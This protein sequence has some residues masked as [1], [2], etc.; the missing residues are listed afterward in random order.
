MGRGSPLRVL[1]LGG[2]AEASALARLLAGEACFTPLLSL[3]GRTVSPV[4][5]PI[6]SRIG[7]FGGADGLAAFLRIEG[8]DLLIDAT[9]PFAHQISINAEQASAAA[10]VPRLVLR[11]PAW[12]PRQGDDWRAVPDMASAAI[13]L[14]EA[15][16]RVFLTIGRQDLLPFQAAAQHHYLIRSV[17]PP[18]P[19]LLPAQADVVSAR[20]PFTADAER[21]L[22]DRCRVEV[23]VTKNSGGADGKLR[24]ARALPLPVIM[25][26]RKPAPSGEAVAEPEAALAWLRAHAE[27]LRGA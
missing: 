4:L 20:G 15:P 25:V 1:I 8:I 16:R 17:D 23:L 7:G 3:A 13:A 18:D 19:A 21:A 24:A 5:P 14:G 26:D 12:T 10:G 27:A 22:M 9:H 2:T 6:P 11:R